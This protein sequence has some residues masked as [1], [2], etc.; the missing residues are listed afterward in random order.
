MFCV[1]VAFMQNCRAD[2]DGKS[3]KPLVK[4][5]FF[6]QYILSITPFV[7]SYVCIIN[8]SLSNKTDL[9]HIVLKQAIKI[10]VNL[11]VLCPIKIRKVPQKH[12]SDFFL[13]FNY[14]F[15]SLFGITIAGL[16]LIIKAPLGFLIKL[17]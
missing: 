17:H 6:T 8:Y 10:T 9:N 16:N 15:K 4:N 5:E 13:F 2:F 1:D 14:I 3:A 7:S 11:I 12:F